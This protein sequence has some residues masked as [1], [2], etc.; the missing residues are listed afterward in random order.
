ML[1]PLGFA[2]AKVTRCRAS[3]ES[4]R[5]QAEVVEDPIR[6][7]QSA[8]AEHGRPRRSRRAVRTQRGRRR[9]VHVHAPDDSESRQPSDVET[10]L[11]D[12]GATDAESSR[13]TARTS[14]SRGGTAEQ[15]AHRTSRSAR[16]LR[17][18]RRQRREHLDRRPDVGRDV[19]RKAVQA[20]VIFFVS[21]PCT[22]RSVRVE[23]GGA[24]DHRGDP[25]H[26]LHVGVYAMF[27]FEV[28]PATVTAFLT[29]LGFS[30][31]DT[32]V[33]FD[34][35]QREPADAARRPAAST[36]RRWSTGR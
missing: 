2:D 18:R 36:Y 30:L 8:L 1:D 24:V 20:L 31:Y 33:V 7:I 28:T 26:H 21:S 16:R 27:Q 35:I 6:T 25:R 13:S 19:S 29:I 15:P 23:D 22:C 32:V 34:K 14:R 5:V 4:V 10:A 11:T 17:G 9:H 3:G 12:A